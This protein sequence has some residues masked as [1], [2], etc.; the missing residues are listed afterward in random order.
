ME[1]KDIIYTKKDHIATI[2]LNRPEVRNAT[3]N[4]MVDEWVTAIEDA[5]MDDDIR[6]LVVTGAGT[7]FCAGADVKD[8][9]TGPFQQSSPAESR[10]NW[11]NGNHRI[12]RA[13]QAL[14]KPYIGAING[15]AAG[16]GMDLASMCDIRIASDEA[17]VSMSY[18]RMGIAPG[19][20]G[21]YF[22][23]RIVGMSKALELIW[24]GRWVDAQEML[25][26]GY[27]SK[28][29]PHEELSAATE[30][31]AADLAKGPP[32]ANQ[33][34]KRLA[35]RGW[36]SDLDTALEMTELMKVINWTTEDSGEGLKAWLEKREPLFKGR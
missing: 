24:T 15:P 29:V 13:L 22:L 14:D 2:M 35:Y 19:G 33:F 18:V 28:V 26:I 7:A 6:V 12:P 21:C 16:W 17:R 30:A 3:S 8:L 1:F 4:K 9:T 11:R 5:R 27:V 10:N 31:F 20:G 36:N 23:P 32:V 34:A 25:Q